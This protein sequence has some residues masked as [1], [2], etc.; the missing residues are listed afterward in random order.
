L[1]GEVSV[2]DSAQQIAVAQNQDGRLEL[3]YIGMDKALYHDWQLAPN[4]AW[5]TPAAF[6][7]AASQMALGSNQDGRLELFYRGID[8]G[9]FHNWQLSPNGGWSGPVS[10]PFCTV[11]QACGAC[12][13]CNDGQCICPQTLS[14]A[15]PQGPVCSSDLCSNHGGVDPEIGCTEQ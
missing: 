3:A 14:C 10:F 12:D 8:G 2:G 5:S 1:L 6:G 9:R 7:G 4:G 11:G 13:F 15:D